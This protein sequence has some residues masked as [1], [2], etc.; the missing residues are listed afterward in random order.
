MKIVGCDLHTRYQQIAMLDA[1]TGQLVERRLEHES[2]EA[3]GGWHTSP[4]GKRRLLVNV[5]RGE[6]GGAPLLAL[7]E[8]WALGCRRSLFSRRCPC[9][10]DL[11][12]RH[13][14]FDIH[15]HIANADGRLGRACHNW[16]RSSVTSVLAVS[17]S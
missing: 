9:K 7:F 10:L 6:N 3:R 11:G 14:A 13:R 17:W 12:A 4:V 1:E 8:K 5:G 16:L 2:G 15:G